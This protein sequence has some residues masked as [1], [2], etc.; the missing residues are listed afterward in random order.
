MVMWRAHGHPISTPDICRFNGF[1]KSVILRVSEAR[2]LG[3]IDRY[4]FYDH[5]KSLAASPPETLHVDEK[6]LREHAV[7]NCT[8]VVVTTN[9]KTN[10]IYLPSDDR[11]HFVAWSDLCKDDFTSK[12]WNDLWRW[13]ADCGFRNVA[14]FLAAYDLKNFDAKAPPPKTPAFWAIVDASRAPEDAELSDVLEALGDALGNRDAEGKPLPPDATTLAYVTAKAE[15]D[16][17]D[18]LKDHR[19]RRLI[20]HRMESC[21]YIPVRNDGA[22][23]GLWKVG[24]ARQVI[25][26]KASLSLS[27]QIKATG[28]LINRVEGKPMAADGGS[29]SSQ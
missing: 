4:K 7:V 29:Q 13:Y 23:D 19:N 5:L 17:K 6:H 28:E 27:D 26:A 12:Y 10:G 24:R 21:G 2:D 8:G 18:W 11:R 20:P 3:E 25:Y 14:A 9:Y 1:I 16:F 15:G 22:K